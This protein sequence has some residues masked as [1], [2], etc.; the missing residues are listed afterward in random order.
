MSISWLI[1]LGLCQ[2]ND[3]E[4]IP[5]STEH[6]VKNIIEEIH[7]TGVKQRTPAYIIDKLNLDAWV[8]CKKSSRETGSAK[9]K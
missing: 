3:N 5:I 1:M 2:D 7:S 6:I 9:T 8:Y 4:D